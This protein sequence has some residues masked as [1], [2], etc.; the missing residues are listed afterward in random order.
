LAGKIAAVGNP[1][2]SAIDLVYMKD[3][4]LFVNL[5][6]DV[7]VWDPLLY[8]SY[9]LGGYQTLSAANNYEPTAGSTATA[10]YPAGVPSPTIQSG[11]AF[12]V[13]SSGPA[14][15]ISF[16]EDCKVNS[17]RLVNRNFNQS[18]KQFFRATLHT[19]SGMIADGNAV[20]FCADYHNRVDADDSW[21]ISNSGEN[22]SMS[23]DG[24]NLSV[25]AR[26]S[27][28]TNDTIF[29]TL[30]NL[31][32]QSYRF[33]FVSKNMTGT[34]LTAILVDN[35]LNS[36]T[37]LNLGDSNW[38][39]IQVTQDP[40]SATP[41]RFYVVFKKSQT[42]L[43][44]TIQ[45][46]ADR[47]DDETVSLQWYVTNQGQVEKYEIERSF[48]GSLYELI[49]TRD[50]FLQTDPSIQYDFKDLQAGTSDIYYRIR[51][52]E[53]NGSTRLSNWVKVYAL[54][55]DPSISVYPNP[56]VDKNMYLHFR[57]LEAGEYIAILYNSIGEMIF[58]KTL[59]I[60]ETNVVK[61][62]HLEHHI[63]SGIYHLRISG[64]N[65]EIRAL[66]VIIR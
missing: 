44:K 36:K 52:I 45:L 60:N 10:Y 17:N 53:A 2:A 14:G 24:K 66:Q 62:L 37:L 35:F 23:R 31:R 22:F 12:F 6:N 30:S 18:E 54:P 65:R 39:N 19:Q 57:N 46:K 41:G 64:P 63:A 49:G 38:I 33:C 26:S 13:R 15:S 1:Y 40:L 47:I 28:V 8:G 27:V 34:L 16:T 3:N 5:N 32:I 4:G 11:Q 21:K 48:D 29:Y 50:A 9:G 55:V 7:T 58:K 20:V 59:S 56:V 25:E 43:V 61:L 51:M 42:D